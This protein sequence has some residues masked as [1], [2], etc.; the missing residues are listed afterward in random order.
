MKK[1]ENPLAAA[2]VVS[3]LAASTEMDNYS[4]VWK[5][6]REFRKRDD[7]GSFLTSFAFTNHSVKGGE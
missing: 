1:E 4:E 2:L 5:S 3:E 6:G 7:S